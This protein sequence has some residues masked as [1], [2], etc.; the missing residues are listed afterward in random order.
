MTKTIEYTMQKIIDTK[1]WYRQF[2]PWLIVALPATVVV[3]A[4]LT[5]RLALH[6]ADDMVVDNYYKDGKAINQRL[7]QDQRATALGLVAELSFNFDSGLLNVSLSGDDMPQ[8]LRLQLMH[9][10]EADNDR[11]IVLQ[12]QG[13]GSY[14]GDL[15]QRLQHRYLLRLLPEGASEDSAAEWRLNGEID[16]NRGQ[17]AVL[18]AD[19]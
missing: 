7:E 1:P 15:G 6:S 4:I 12:Q 17:G 9:P 10:M 2:W 19:Q 8:A 18:I 16:F 3:A 11:E 13:Q 14:R 5:V